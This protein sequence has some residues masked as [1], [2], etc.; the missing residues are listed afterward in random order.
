MRRFLVH[1]LVL[2]TFVSQANAQDDPLAAAE[3]HR[4]GLFNRLAPSVVYIRTKEGIGSGFFIS[5]DGAILTNAHVV[6]KFK[7]VTVVTFDGVKLTGTVIERAKLE[8]GRAGSGITEGRDVALVKVDMKSK[9][10]EIASMKDL[11]IG[12]W[13]G[14]IGHSEGRALWSFTSGYVSNVYPQIEDNPFFQTQIPV[15]PGNSGGPIFDRRGRVVGIVTAGSPSMNF[16]IPIEV[17]TRRLKT[18]AQNCECISVNVPGKLPV[19]VNGKMVG[20][21]PALLI[22]SKKGTTIEIMVIIDGAMQKREVTYP[23]TKRV[24]FK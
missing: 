22:P 8:A 6:G 17:A 3:K 10:V 7:T 16:A 15:L 24:D 2:L 1:L 5:A 18:V 12:S 13:V 21:G 20:N 23:K 9:P 14:A 11:K 19:Y 4:Q